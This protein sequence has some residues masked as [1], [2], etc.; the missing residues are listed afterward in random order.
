MSILTHLLRHATLAVVTVA[1]CSLSLLASAQTGTTRNPPVVH[2]RQHLY[3]VP[4]LGHLSG[5]AEAWMS[6][7][8]HGGSHPGPTFNDE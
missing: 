6:G 5:A 4:A 1:G 2:K 7:R 3:R 8:Y